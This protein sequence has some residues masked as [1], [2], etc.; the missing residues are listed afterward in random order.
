MGRSTTRHPA[1]LP[2]GER[3]QHRR[4]VEHAPSTRSD[5][6]QSP[7]IRFAAKPRGWETGQFGKFVQREKFCVHALSID[8][9]NP[10]QS[11]DD[12]ALRIVTLFCA[13]LRFCPIGRHIS[14]PP[15]ASI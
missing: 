9:R 12:R 1:S 10:N 6:R 2:L 11:D 15:L 8:A 13:S 3:L 5:T 4:D 14:G 7:R